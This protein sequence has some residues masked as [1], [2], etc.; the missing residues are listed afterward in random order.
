MAARAP[1]RSSSHGLF[2]LVAGVG[3]AVLTSCGATEETPKARVASPVDQQ[4]TP[5][6]SA[7]YVEDAPSKK[8]REPRLTE[9]DEDSL[10][11]PFSRAWSKNVP[12]RTCSKDDECG[13]GFCDRTACAPI[14][15]G[16][17]GYG[18]RCGPD[19]RRLDCGGGRVCIDG[20]CRSCLAHAECPRKFA[21]C[22]R[23]D[24]P[25]H[26]NG[27]SCAVL[28]LKEV[29]LPPEPPPPRPLPAPAAPPSP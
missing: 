17:V 3:I 2:V 7:P 1:Q 23:M 29:A 8:P 16:R 28:G 6:A 18:Q 19:T 10:D 9:F 21:V 11:T 12:S 5:P 4:A 25:Y 15:I 22:N 13:D 27:N 26:P 14:W 20:R 24:S